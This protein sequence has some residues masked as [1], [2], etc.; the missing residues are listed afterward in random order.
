MGQHRNTPFEPAS[1][2]LDAALVPRRGTPLVKALRTAAS[3]AAS[4]LTNDVEAG[5]SAIDLVV[6]RRE[7]GGEVLRVTA[8]GAQEADALLLRVRRDLAT[9]DV[10]EFI[11]EWRVVPEEP[12]SADD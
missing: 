11:S 10:A 4:L 12:A 5:P 2:Y 6:S 1:T 9:K 8:G 3:I 7:S